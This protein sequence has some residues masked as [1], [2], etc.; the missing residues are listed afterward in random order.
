M[1]R[2]KANPASRRAQQESQIRR[3]VIVDALKA[4][5]KDTTIVF[6]CHSGARSLDAA[7]YFIGHGFTDVKS[8]T[9]GINAWSEQVDP[10]VP[11][12]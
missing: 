7:A 4:A 10:S 6:H 3:L 11:K 9:G 2:A 1:A 12:Y 8:M 5:P